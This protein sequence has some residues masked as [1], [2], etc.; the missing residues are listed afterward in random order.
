[1]S[2]EEKTQHC[3][4]LLLLLFDLEIRVIEMRTPLFSSDEPAT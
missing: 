3:L 4:Q 1:M 2:V